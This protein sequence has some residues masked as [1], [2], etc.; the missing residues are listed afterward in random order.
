MIS[1]S[2]PEEESLRVLM[3]AGHGYGNLGDE[4]QLAAN[5][6]RWRRQ[7]PG[8]RLQVWSPH[9][10]YTVRQHG[11]CAEPAPRVVWFDANRN[12]AYG[13]STEG[14]Q[15]QFWRVRERMLKAAERLNRGLH[16]WGI[17]DAELA[18]LKQIRQAHLLHVSGGGFM[19]G[20]T[21]SRLW[22]TCLV[23]NLA[24]VMG[25]PA[26]L[27]GQTIGVFEMEEDRQLA[28]W[29]LEHAAVIELRDAG[30]SEA[31]V[32]ALGISGEHVYSRFDDALFCT[33]AEPGKVRGL[34]TSLGVEGDYIAANCHHWNQGS[35][36]REKAIRQFSRLCDVLA[37]R[38]GCPVVLVPMHESDQSAQQ[39]AAEAMS[40]ESV[41]VPYEEGFDYRLARGVFADSL[42]VI[43]FKH[44]PLVFALGEG[45][46]T[47]SV[48]VDP[49]YDHKNH[50]A[51]AL[52]GQEDYSLT[53][54]RFLSA[55][56]E[57][58]ATTWLSRLDEERRRI[59]AF[60]AELKKEEMAFIESAARVASES[61]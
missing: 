42:G 22:E 29:G 19:T 60:G 57:Q 46:P 10:A 8:V 17:N 12:G 32:R 39:H 35:Q 61:V 36:M 2:E 18:L 28:L 43:S 6:E 7:V 14:F 45:V 31:E 11:I 50:F 41:L 4:A 49:Y 44:H 25:T 26:V 47:L 59:K 30:A 37:E 56:A 24:H 40:C 21:R 52:F 33:R 27:S 38:S 15:A 3:M 51:L 48:S 1:V 54:D 58:V 20:S 9:P 34:L 23:L 16:P 5:I 55:A 13:A 53:A